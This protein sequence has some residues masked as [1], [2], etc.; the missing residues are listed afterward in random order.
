MSNN[1]YPF[2]HYA[3]FINSEEILLR[4]EAWKFMDVVDYKDELNEQILKE[5][6]EAIEEMS[7][8]LT[9]LRFASDEEYYAKYGHEKLVSYHESLDPTLYCKYCSLEDKE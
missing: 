6:E 5:L 9:M 2:Q 7:I 4:R 1:T 3:G 8:Y